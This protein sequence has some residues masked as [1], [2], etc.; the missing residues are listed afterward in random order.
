MISQQLRSRKTEEE[1]DDT[2][3]TA[4]ER[5]REAVREP[6][7][8]RESRVAEFCSNYQNPAQPYAKITCAP[9]LH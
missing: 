7:E 1:A 3:S 9:N 4:G 6:Q 8:A 5:V 2:V